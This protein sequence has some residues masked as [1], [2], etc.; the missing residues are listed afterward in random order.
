M[1]MCVCSGHMSMTK[2]AVFTRR[3]CFGTAVLD[4]KNACV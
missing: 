3:K 1:Y 2:H 4:D